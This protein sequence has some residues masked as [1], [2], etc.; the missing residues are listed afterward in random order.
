MFSNPVKVA[1]VALTI[2]TA[3]TA[4][5][6][7]GTM[8]QQNACRSDVFTLCGSYIPNVG[9]IIACLRG[10]EASLSEPCHQVMFPD[11]AAQDDYQPTT[12][13]RSGGVQ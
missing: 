7:Q 3:S 6:A 13:I 5:F 2:S 8:Q 11:Q 10:H 1:A 4:A 12:R 9:D